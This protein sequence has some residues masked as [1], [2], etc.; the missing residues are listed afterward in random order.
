MKLTEND[1]NL[2]RQLHDTNTGKLL[3]EYLERLSDHL[4]DSRSWGPEDTKES[5][6]KAALVIKTGIIDKIVLQTVPKE[7]VNEFE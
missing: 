3:V 7:V 1:K 6:N 4:C 2:F 5:T